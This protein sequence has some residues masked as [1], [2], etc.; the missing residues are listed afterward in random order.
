[1]V[2][3]IAENPVL[4]LFIVVGLGAAIGTVKVF[5]VSLGPAAALFVG[6]AL[7]AY[8]EKLALPEGLQALGLAL[9]TYTVGLAGGPA[10]AAGMRKGGVR[11]VL[12]VVGM[13]VAL[14]GAT[15]AV[16]QLSGLDRGARAGL[17]AG[18]TTNTPALAAAI[19]DLKDAG[20]SNPTTAYS[21]AYPVGVVAMILMAAAMLRRGETHPPAA[22]MATPAPEPATSRTVLVRRA[23]LPPLGDLSR[24]AGQALTFSRF[25]HAD[26]VAMATAEVRL[27]PGDLVVV[28]GPEEAVTAFT[29]WSG[30]RSDEHLALDR[31]NLDFRRMVV[32]N[33]HLAGRRIGD[34]EI[35]ARHGAVITRVRRG[36]TDLVARDD[37]TLQLGDRVRVV[38][39]SDR[40]AAVARELGDSDRS[41]FEF[42]AIAF[43]IG[44]VAGALIGLVNLPLPGASVKLGIGG[45]TLIAGLV[46]GVL[47]RTGPL[48]W[49][50]PQAANLTLRQLGTLVFLACVGTRSGT[51]FADALKTHTGVR[52]IG[53][54]V[55]VCTVWALLSSLC[56]R[57]LLQRSPAESAGFLAGVQTQ[58]AVLSFA[59]ERTQG[60]DRVA[61]AYALALPLAMVAKIVLVQYL[62]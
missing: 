12:V 30:E 20:T 35:T 21:L 29:E 60:D 10:F 28:V 56:I 6:L 3:T 46:L 57:F 31:R 17:F 59:M 44:M 39:P 9:F 53:A 7:S 34:L 27:V 40:L 14:T 33:R 2:E 41:L 37:L 1:V 4:L 13:L 16:A 55:V 11:V 61:Y 8:D 62:A 43:S 32:S 19:N 50:V 15:Y 22:P 38:G 23:E 36:D 45:G 18:S 24:F 25:R 49:Q 51:Q 52:I 47:A 42:D 48:T 54:A 5:G 26:V 58:P